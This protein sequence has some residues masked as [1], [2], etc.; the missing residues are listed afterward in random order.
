VAGQEVGDPIYRG[1]ARG[2]HAWYEA[3]AGDAVPG[4]PDGHA[5]PYRH[6]LGETRTSR[7]TSWTYDREVAITYAGEGGLLLIWQTGKPPPGAD[8]SFEMSP[9]CFYEQEVL[10]CG[11]LT[12]LWVE[13]L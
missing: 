13:R 9:D 6:N 11:T 2:H 7:F 8:W 10:I 4:D 3:L 5:D 12:G 1:V